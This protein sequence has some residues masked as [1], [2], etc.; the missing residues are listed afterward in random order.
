MCGITVNNNMRRTNE[1]KE[2]YDR[3][4]VNVQEIDSDENDAER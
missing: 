2:D 1:F 4:D 3:K